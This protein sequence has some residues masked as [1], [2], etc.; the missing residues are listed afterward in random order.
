MGLVCIPWK[1][2][3]FEIGLP[4]I[5][6]RPFQKLLISAMLKNTPPT[7][8]KNI[9]SCIYTTTTIIYTKPLLL[10]TL[11]PIMIITLA[12]IITTIK[13][14]SHKYDNN[15]NKSS[16]NSNN[17]NKKANHTPSHRLPK[18]IS[19]PSFCS[20]SLWP[21]RVEHLLNSL[22]TSAVRE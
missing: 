11:Q 4:E 13:I 22:T 17:N 19:S 2:F 16:N 18:N 14:I 5:E 12:T 20:P 8:E 21:S 10:L 7:T 6:K 15:Q 9:S 1:L 3:V